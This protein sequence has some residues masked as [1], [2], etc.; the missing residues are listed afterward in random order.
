M[1]G[2]IKKIE[3]GIKNNK[4]NCLVNKNICSFIGYCESQKVIYKERK[5]VDNNG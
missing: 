3:C 4:C 2:S 5:G 1:I